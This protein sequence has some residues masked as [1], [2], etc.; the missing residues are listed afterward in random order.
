MIRYYCDLCKIEVFPNSIDPLTIK[1]EIKYVNHNTLQLC[2]KC[3]SEVYDL[4]L[5]KCKK[6]NK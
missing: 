6:D 1:M 5:S 2:N 3:S 4:I